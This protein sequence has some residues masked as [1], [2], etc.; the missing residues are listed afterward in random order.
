VATPGD[1]TARFE[2]ELFM[3][4]MCPLA[5]VPGGSPFD[6]RY[7]RLKWEHGF[8]IDFE[9][10]EEAEAAIAELR[11]LPEFADVTMTVGEG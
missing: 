3:H 8:P 9:T 2:R 5:G 7:E 6:N 11:E 4:T 1:L 10:R